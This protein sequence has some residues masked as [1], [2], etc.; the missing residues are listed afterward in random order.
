MTHI[1]ESL[2]KNELLQLSFEREKSQVKV[3]GKLQAAGKG[4]S[5]KLNGL[6]P[7]SGRS[8]RSLSRYCTCSRPFTIR[9]VHFQDR[10]LPGPST[11]R[12]V[13]IELT[14]LLYWFNYLEPPTH[15]R[16]PAIFRNASVDFVITWI[17]LNLSLNGRLSI[18]K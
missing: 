18:V 14:F 5:T 10:S 13:H 3:D 9:T 17:F 4:W 12:I 6:Q 15:Y 7:N 16:N 8:F 11:F 2:E 1:Y